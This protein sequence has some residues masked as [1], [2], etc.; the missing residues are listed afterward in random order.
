MKKITITLTVLMAFTIFVN[1]QTT[2]SPTT[3]LVSKKGYTI[4]PQAGDYAIGI[5]A[6]PMLKYAGNIFNN[7]ANNTA[8]FNFK[9]GQS[10]YSQTKRIFL[11]QLTG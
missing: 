2:T 5:D 11:F 6:V 7:T 4:L 9:E 10:I 3:P 8:A 1:A